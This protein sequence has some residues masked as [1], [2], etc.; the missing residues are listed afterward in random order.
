MTVG[1]IGSGTV[2]GPSARLRD[3]GHAGGWAPATPNARTSP[4]GPRRRA[5]GRRH[6]HGSCRLWRSPRARH[7]LGRHGERDPASWARTTPGKVVIDATNPSILRRHAPA[8]DAEASGVIVQRWLPGAHV[9]KAFNTVGAPLMVDP[10]L[11]GG[12]P[13]MFI[14]G[15]T[16]RPSPPFPTSSTPSAGR[17]STSAG[18]DLALPRRPGDDL[19]RPRDA[20]GRRRPRLQAARLASG[21]AA[22]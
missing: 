4:S 11:D 18:S 1:I 20:E 3:H 7:R 10:H 14:A 2:G 6:K 8:G 9:V 5:T 19:D 21:A 13:T 17:P 12:P 22:V 16:P 15:E